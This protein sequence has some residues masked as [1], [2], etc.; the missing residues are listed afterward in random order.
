MVVVVVLHELRVV[1][2]MVIVVVVAIAVLFQNISLSWQ[3]MTP[4]NWPIVP[5]GP[6]FRQPYNRQLQAH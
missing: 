1:V 5:P 4:F 3:R 6:L 2:V